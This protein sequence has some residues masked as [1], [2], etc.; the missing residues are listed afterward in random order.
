MEEEVGGEV[1]V[2]VGGGGGGVEV[3]S[4]NREKKANSRCDVNKEKTTPKTNKEKRTPGG[5][6]FLLS[7]SG[8]GRAFVWVRVEFAWVFLL[9]AADGAPL[10]QFFEERN[11]T[12][13]RISP[14]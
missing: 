10:G 3:E 9:C 5:F 6:F 13:E 7:G 1:V 8:S 14:E 4:R 2:V 11:L 12:A